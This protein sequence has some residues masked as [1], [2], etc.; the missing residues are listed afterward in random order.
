MQAL[1]N[2]RPQLLHILKCPDLAQEAGLS[3]GPGEGET[4]ITLKNC[5][6]SHW[7]S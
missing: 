3:A 5:F 1:M 6:V 2:I 4:N 7:P